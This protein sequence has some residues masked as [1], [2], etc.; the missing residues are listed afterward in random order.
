MQGVG[1]RPFVWALADELGIR[2]TVANDAGG[3]LIH[4]EG[5]AVE[6]FE[7]AL[8]ICPPR[9]SRV[10]AVDGATFEFTVP[11]S[12]FEIVGSTSGVVRTGVTPDAATCDDCVAE[13]ANPKGRRA[14]YAFTNCTNCGPRFTIL[15]Q[16]PYDRSRTSMADFEMCA[17]CQA[18]Y[19]DPADRR[20]HAQPIACPD[21]GPRLWLEV[22]G[23]EV[24][25][26]PMVLAVERLNSGKILAIKGLGGF[27]LSCDA[28]NAG[29]ISRLRDRKR[30]PTKPLALMGTIKALSRHVAMSGAEISR[31]QDPAAPIVLVD[32]AGLPL[33]DGLAPGMAQLGVMLPNTPLHH[34]LV[35]GFGG[36]PLVMTSGNPS[37]EPQVI[38]NPEARSKLGSIA[39]AFVMHDRGIVRRVD[40]SVERVTPHGPMSLRRAR[41]R[42]PAPRKLPPGFEDAPQVCAYG[43]Q[44]KS[45]ICLT[46]DGEAIVS[47]HLGDLDDA[48][49]WD[50]FRKTDRDYRDLFDHAPEV[51][52]VDLHPGY[53]A[54]EYGRANAGGRP[55]VAVQHHHAHLA[56]VM[57]DAG[58]G[59]KHGPVAG[60]ILDGLGLGDDGSIW[61]GEVLVGDYASAR[62]VA[63]LTQAPLVGGDAAQREPWRNLLVRL[64]QAGMAARADT[65]FADRPIAVLRQA[66]TAGVNAP[67]SSSAGRLFDAV[68]NA[69]GL[70][71]DCQSFEGEAAM[72][73]EACARGGAGA[74]YDFGRAPYVQ[75]GS[76]TVALDPSEMLRALLADLDAGASHHDVAFRF[77]AGLAMAFA[78][79]ARAQVESGAA[80]SVA[81]SG[82]CLQNALLLDLLVHELG[83]LDVLF[84]RDIPANDGG[85]A[86]GQ[87]LVAA[88]RIIAGG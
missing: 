23:A 66:A 31:L 78:A 41:G 25:G 52:A 80:R 68:A 12:C 18:E 14:N 6:A 19:D 54:T 9:L 21:C 48:L 44:L 77:H 32:K 57:G 81:L 64:D 59:R 86:F 88:A 4:A 45:T 82:G 20:F 42:C 5:P 69:L 73:L 29:A 28:M 56:S 11:P 27:H 40:D 49:A 33:P 50:E 47:H 55:V 65:L 39:D 71:D 35:E 7:Q 53:R 24:S 84:H 8:S 63:H 74:G 85:L 38:G 43:G 83:G 60:I 10:D 15:R 13:I 16:L 70:A 26:D 22:D 2:G 30:R 58:W 75:N 79:Q 3:V 76:E 1:F 17:A 87:A 46:K 37:G 34:L 62:R 72:L 67:M 61:G 51:V 36:G